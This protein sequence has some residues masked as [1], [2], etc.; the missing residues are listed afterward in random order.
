MI[1][2]SKKIFVNKIDSE[3][4]NKKIIDEFNIAKDC[5]HPNI[6]SFIFL[7]NNLVEHYFHY[8]D[9]F[10][11]EHVIV[12]EYME[13]GSLEDLINKNR[14]N[15]KVIDENMMKIYISQILSGLEH[16]HC[17]KHIIHRDIK[18]ANLLIADS[19]NVKISDFG[20]S[21]YLHSGGATIK[22][23][24]LYMAPEILDVR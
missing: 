10:N 16:L 6:G 23:T 9:D 3:Y 20:E 11:S 2:A 5:R 15:N 22:G 1:F 14:K 4:K 8:F 7:N 18:P 13:E 24:P 21:K 19:G 12:M 17:I